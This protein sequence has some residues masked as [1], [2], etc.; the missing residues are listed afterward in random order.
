MALNQYILI[1]KKKKTENKNIVSFIQVPLHA[2]IALFS[3][4]FKIIHWFTNMMI[5]TGIQDQ[6][7][8]VIDSPTDFKDINVTMSTVT[9]M[10]K[11]QQD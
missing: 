8:Y 10:Y 11:L 2:T 4:S 3:I 5:D 6:I 1:V 7:I 9:Y